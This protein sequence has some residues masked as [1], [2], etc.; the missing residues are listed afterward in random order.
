MYEYRLRYAQSE[1]G[2]CGRLTFRTGTT[3]SSIVDIPN[4]TYGALITAARCQIR[5]IAGNLIA[6]P[7]TSVNTLTD[8]QVVTATVDE[9]ITNTWEV[10]FNKRAC[11]LYDFEFDLNNGNTVGTYPPSVVWVHKGVTVRDTP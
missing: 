11:Y 5:D 6:T 4:D 10:P 7:K 8:S 2:N 3:F 9:A 1:D